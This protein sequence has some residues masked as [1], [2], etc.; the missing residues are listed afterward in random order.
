[1]YDGKAKNLFQLVLSCQHS[2]KS[3]S[4]E[5]QF[6][7]RLHNKLN[8]ETPIMINSLLLSFCMWLAAITDV[9]MIFK[10]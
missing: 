6:A 2:I 10:Y 1:M 5:K 4:L 9:H 3:I 8:R 7:K